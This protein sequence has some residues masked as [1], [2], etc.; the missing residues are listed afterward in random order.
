MQTT[1]GARQAL[2]TRQNFEDIALKGRDF[3]GMLKLL[4]GVIDTRVR[5]AP[6][7]ESMNNLT[8]NGQ[9]NFN[10]SYDG[11]TNKDTGQ[12]RANF[13]A[14]ALDSIAEVRV[15]SSNFNAEY[16]RS[17]GATISVVTRSGSKD[18]RGSAAFYK[19]DDALN[20]N[21]Y[22]RRVS[23][24]G[25]TAVACDAA[26]LQVRQLRVDARRPRAHPGHRLQQEP[27]QAVL[28]LVAGHPAAQGPRQPEPAAD[29]DRAR[30]AGATSRRRSTA[31]AA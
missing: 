9:A 23:C 16:G 12:N 18:F 4:P 17:S 2:I 30:A 1:S 27:Q 5:D 21:E 20:G 11:V 10:Y 3:A 6:G 7:W 29:A 15:Q 14:P 26:S 25:G 24:A 13:A 8:I 22:A 19:R 28:L 31:R